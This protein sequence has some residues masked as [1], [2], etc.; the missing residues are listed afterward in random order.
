[1]ALEEE[2]L[3]FV[4]LTI[5]VVFIS[6][7]AIVVFSVLLAFEVILTTG[8]EV[9]SFEALTFYLHLH[10]ADSSPLVFVIFLFRPI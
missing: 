9:F 10:F 4:P 3:I 7:G 6:Q 1:M 8:F 5:L 2:F